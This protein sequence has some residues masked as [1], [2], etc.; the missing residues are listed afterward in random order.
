MAEQKPPS[1]AS[2]LAAIMSEVEAVPKRGHND[3]FGYDFATEADVAAAIRK[4]LAVRNVALLPSVTGFKDETIVTRG[5]RGEKSK[6]I[7]TVTMRYVFKDGDSGEE[8]P[9]EWAGRGEDSSDK[10]L[11]KAITGGNKYFLLKCFQIP[12]GDDPEIDKRKERGAQRRSRETVEPNGDRVNR[13]TGEVRP[14]STGALINAGQ[15]KELI[16]AGHKAG[17]TGK[18]F[19]SWLKQ[20]GYGEWSKIPASAFGSVMAIMKG[21]SQA[22]EDSHAA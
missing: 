6:T 5:E 17:W 1:L 21:G 3:H 2:K 15:Q 22:G 20:S 12:T 19:A 11:F 10:G 16:E 18:D 8:F 9:C 7:T 4:G 14:A 13:N